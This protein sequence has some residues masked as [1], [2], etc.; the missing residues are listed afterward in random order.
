M[1]IFEANEFQEKI[2]KTWHSGL[3]IDIL[4][5][6][7][8]TYAMKLLYNKFF[9]SDIEDHIQNLKW[10]SDYVFCIYGINSQY[11]KNT[12]ALYNVAGIYPILLVLCDTT[13]PNDFLDKIR[14]ISKLKEFL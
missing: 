8:I 13:N 10:D 11:D 7:E 2:S 5:R 12:I 9:L 6:F 3:L 4:D 14:K 1:I